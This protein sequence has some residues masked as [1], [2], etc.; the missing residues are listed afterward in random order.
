MAPPA[1]PLDLT[2]EMTYQLFS[3]ALV[4][5][6][7]NCVRVHRHTC[8][9][10]KEGFKELQQSAQ[11]SLARERLF[12]T[13]FPRAIY[14]TIMQERERASGGPF[15]IN[16]DEF[17]RRRQVA[18][19]AELEE[20]ELG[21]APD[22]SARRAKKKPSA[23]A[24][25]RGSGGGGAGRRRVVPPDEAPEDEQ[26]PQQLLPEEA[27]SGADPAPPAAKS[28]GPGGKR[29]AKSKAVCNAASSAAEP[30]LPV[31]ELAFDGT[32]L[33]VM[34]TDAA[35]Y[36]E[37]GEGSSDEEEGCG[38]ERFGR[39]LFTLRVDVSHAVRLAEIRSSIS[40]AISDLNL[41]ELALPT[42]ADAALW[43][44]PGD[45]RGVRIV[46]TST[47][48]EAILGARR[49]WLAPSVQSSPKTAKHA[50]DAPAAPAPEARSDL[51]KVLKNGEAVRIYRGDVQGNSALD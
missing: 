42:F 9:R 47:P 31:R 3:V 39:V 14:R 21:E 19:E 22:T 4:L 11:Q 26:Q 2:A 8:C 29:A 23:G 46:A 50:F 45:R 43:Y 16:L 27:A 18:A 34:I 51:T 33:T 37:P 49:V 5:L 41:P 10:K 24:V 12:W 20:A 40:S 38:M 13:R 32:Q 17:D 36:R 1:A 7:L 15:E 30:P 35:G 44:A 48:R 6:A 25:A 28:K